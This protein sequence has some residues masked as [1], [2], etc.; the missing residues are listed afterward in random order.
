[1]ALPD[2]V[3]KKLQEEENS[4]G[5]LPDYV[6][7]AMN[8]AQSPAPEI[9]AYEPGPYSGTSTEYYTPE[10][11]DDPMAAMSNSVNTPIDFAGI[12]KATGRAMDYVTQPIP[13]PNSTGQFLTENF[14]RSINRFSSAMVAGTGGMIYNAAKKLTDPIANAWSGQQDLSSAAKDLFYAP[15]DAGVETFNALAHAT[16]APLGVYGKEAAKEAWSD[17]AAATA[18]VLPL[19][20]AA[21]RGMKAYGE[22]ITPEP[23]IEGL[24]NQ[25]GSIVNK[26]FDKGIK[27]KGAMKS[28]ADLLRE[29]ELQA[30]AI[31]EIVKSKEFLKFKDE[32]GETV[33]G[34]VPKGANALDELS[35]S[36]EQRKLATI[37]KSNEANEA[38][39]VA[40]VKVPVQNSINR[41]QEIINDRMIASHQ[42]ELYQYAKE[43][44]E[45]LIKDGDLTPAEGQKVMAMFNQSKAVADANPSMALVARAQIDAIVANNL[46]A[47]LNAAVEGNQGPGYS[48]NRQKFGALKS[49]EEP[50]NTRLKRYRQQNEKSALNLYDV[51]SYNDL[52]AGAGQVAA[53]NAMSGIGNILKGIGLKGVAEQI[54]RGKDP[55]RA[56][57]KMFEQAEAI[58][59][60][61]QKLMSE[62]E[63]AGIVAEFNSNPNTQNQLALPAPTGETSAYQT[64]VDI[65]RTPGGMEFLTE[66]LGRTKGDAETLRTIKEALTDIP[67][68]N[69]PL[70]PVPNVQVYHI[71][72]TNALGQ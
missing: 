54:K 12:G 53:G 11:S 42:P 56:I 17:P 20:I 14:P 27:P 68:T 43:K 59:P 35:Q 70:V 6:V 18:A 52:F 61:L 49:I 50:V 3:L 19:G 37:T 21:K 4:G 55:N 26:G 24:Q 34:K 36:I 66:K 40:G 71:P 2:Y 1:M 25:L 32:F 51:F 48:A 39:G 28:R 22:Y 64:I 63:A 9:P 41:L 5:G 15:R 7:A 46:R 57:S 10:I 8:Q 33:T 13:V 67:V 31:T 69:Y 38:A 62:K 16:G 58:V 23:T 72:K 44:L 60:K 65:S 47:D 30:K 29:R 45:T